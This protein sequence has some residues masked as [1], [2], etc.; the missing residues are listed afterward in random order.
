V[1][2]LRASGTTQMPAGA[3][4]QIHADD[5]GRIKKAHRIALGEAVTYVH[6]EQTRYPADVE[7]RYLANGSV[8]ADGRLLDISVGGAF[9]RTMGTLPQIGADIQ[10]EMRP[11]GWFFR[12]LKVKARVMWLDF[13]EESRGMGVRFMEK[14]PKVETLVEKLRG[15]A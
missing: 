3:S 6:R 13:F 1:R 5:R 14:N 12:K 7:V 2:W 9:I 15:N 8:A 4:L 10:V 11:P